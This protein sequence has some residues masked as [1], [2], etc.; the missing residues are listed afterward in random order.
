[1][2]QST[3]CLYSICYVVYGERQT[4]GYSWECF[5][6]KI[7]STN[8]SGI[9]QVHLHFDVLAFHCNGAVLHTVLESMLGWFYTVRAYKQLICSEDKAVNHFTAH[10]QQRSTNHY[11]RRMMVHKM[12]SVNN[13]SVRYETMVDRFKLWRI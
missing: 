4:L 13:L 11:V 6:R 12:R 10:N 1:M 5:W 8:H 3:W 2:G 7:Q 9:F